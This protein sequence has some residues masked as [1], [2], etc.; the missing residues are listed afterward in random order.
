VFK[1]IVLWKFKDTAEGA[2]KTENLR[3]AKALLD[4]LPS[5]IPHVASFEVG[6]DVLH[7]DASYD[8]VLNSSFENKDEL[9]AYQQHPDHVRVVEFLR[10]V[11]AGKVVVDYVV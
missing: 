8:L 11:H 2:T 5:K 3:T 7:S 9:L 6:I 10:R 1:H 4:S